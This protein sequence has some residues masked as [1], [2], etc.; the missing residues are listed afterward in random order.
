M[1]T[2]LNTEVWESVLQEPLFQDGSFVKYL[3]SF[4]SRTARKTVNIGIAGT[5]P[6]VVV[7]RQSK[8]AAIQQRA[9]TITTMDLDEYSTDPFLLERSEVQFLGY[10]KVK[11]LLAQHTAT[12]YDN[13]NRRAMFNSSPEGTFAAGRTHVLTTGT[14]RALGTF[15]S[16]GP[17]GAT[18]NRL[19]PT[20]ADI[21]AL[22]L[23]LDNQ[24]V[25]STGRYLL[26]HSAHFWALLQI[27]DLSRLD[28]YGLSGVRTGQ[29][30][31]VLG[32]KLL[33]PVSNTPVYNV[34]TVARAAFGSNGTAAEASWSSL[35]F[36]PAFLGRAMGAIEV[37]ENQ[38]D[39]TMYGDVYSALMFF[40]AAKL[41]GTANVGVVS[42]LSNN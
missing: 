1:A 11:S 15:P 34:D 6:N 33:P 36:H 8:P 38:G 3:T 4:D 2:S 39:A 37:F 41:R 27:A 5:N 13:V 30:P 40:G 9:D 25:P 35:A 26:P 17:T 42:L 21:A 29:L 28:A 31:E 23:A 18:G 22:H 12:L 16:N 24:N 19:D 14:S 32:F 10:D 7:N 20:V